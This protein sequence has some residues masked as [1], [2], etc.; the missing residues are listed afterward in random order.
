LLGGPIGAHCESLLR[1]VDG[2]EPLITH[3]AAPTR[4]ILTVRAEGPAEP[5]AFFDPDPA[6]TAAEA[7]HLHRQVEQALA[8][9]EVDAITLSGS[10][11]AAA[12]HGTYSD[13]I[14]LARSRMVPAFLD[15]Y[16]PALRSIWGFWPDVIQLN[17]REAS[18]HLRVEHPT[19]ADLFQM[20]EGWSRR[21]VKTG[22]ITNGPGVV[23]VVS[24]GRHYQAI[25]PKIRAINPIGSGDCLLAGI[26][27]GWLAGLETEAMIRRGIAC[28]VSN[29]LVWDAAA[30]DPGKAG[31][32]EAGISVE[33]VLPR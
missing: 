31:E 18:A 12:T 22:V 21:G 7:D 27:D 33:P 6:I 8:E 32:L 25:P 29:A 9:E 5:T 3:T 2:F 10:S 1:H 17:R 30:I 11:P 28:A 20:L 19:D 14:S 16:G 26:V 24:G 13:L 4:T 15:T 23:L